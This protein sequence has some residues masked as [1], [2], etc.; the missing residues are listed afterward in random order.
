MF[1]CSA[2][3]RAFSC[4]ESLAR[5]TSARSSWTRGN[6]HRTPAMA[7]ATTRISS[8]DQAGDQR[9][10]LAPTPDTLQLRRAARS[11]RFV[12]QK[13]LDI[14]RERLGRGVALGGFLFEA[15]QADR[16]KVAIYFWI[17]EARL[18]RLGVQNQ[19]DG[20]IGCSASKRWMASEQLVKHCAKSVNIRG[21]CELR[22]ISHRLFRRHVTGRAQNFHR[23]RDSALRLDQ[24]GQPEIGEMR[25]AF[26]VEQNVS[27]LD[28]S[29][30]DAVLMRVVKRCGPAWRSVPLRDGSVSVRASRRHRVG[31]PPP[32]PC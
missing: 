9:F 15:L 18:S 2:S 26:C 7:T 20:F 5:R 22:V 29:M 3:R 12:A 24:P 28:V 13:P 6:S 16:C 8:R 11:N 30:Q 19:P 17:S 1:V 10:P 21:A 14:L 27:G 31:R 25:F 32:V 23:A 4:A